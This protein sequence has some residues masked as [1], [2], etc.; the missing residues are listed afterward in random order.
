MNEL[1]VV[2]L[3]TCLAL[4]TP[5]MARPTLPFGVQV[6]AARVGTPEIV[7]L[8]RIYN[9]LILAVAVVAAALTVALQAGPTVTA[10]V[11]GTVDMALY[12][13]AYRRLRAIK[14]REWWQAE[15]R[16]GV[17]VDTTFRTDP[18]CVP[19]L[20]LLPAVLVLLVTLIVGW[21]RDLGPVL[22]QA[23]VVLLAPLVVLLIVRA[24]PD[25]DAAKPVG[26]ARRYRVYLRGVARAIL[27]LATG[28]NV[29]IFV[30]ALQNWSI[31]P[32][33]AFWTMVG[34]VPIGI[35]V[36]GFLVWEMRVGQAGHRLSAL[37]GEEEEDTG[38]VQRDD[39]RYWYLA[40]MIY[41]NRRDPAVLVHRR[42][43]AYWTLNVGHPVAWVLIAA[44]VVTGLLSGFDV[45]DLPERSSR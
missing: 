14:R 30:H 7:G 26:S 25:L 41:A 24:R 42:V 45:I 17:T 23:W 15:H 36:L 40:G 33:T 29:Q 3:L 28:I 37:P 31:L 39:D 38:V 35:A 8:R 5:A 44:I 21:S 20:W 10:V 22:V 16:H 32:S 1:G 9:R 18:V 43:G 13:G 11:V 6:A 34:L 12:Y 27:V 19:L 2:T 4:A